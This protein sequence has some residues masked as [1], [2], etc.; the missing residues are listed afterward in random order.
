[1]LVPSPAE[2]ERRFVAAQVCMLPR[3]A[4]ATSADTEESA[5]TGP[6]SNASAFTLP[7]EA[8]DLM[9]ERFQA[10]AAPSRLAIL[11]VLM[12]GERTVQELEEA[13]ALTQTNV[14]RHL[15][16]LR[17]AGIVT[18]TAHGNRALYRIADPTIEA[19]CHLVCNSLAAR[20]EGQMGAL[21]GA[22]PD[23]RR[24]RRAG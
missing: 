23:P 21:D 18:R 19:L 11:N 7:P 15:A 22:R 5:M 17:Q 12:Q 2:I 1:M 16:V 6:V 24:K 20:L 9:A 10:L 14:S 8:F 13:T 4:A 3:H